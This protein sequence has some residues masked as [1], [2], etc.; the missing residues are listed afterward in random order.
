MVVTVARQYFQFRESDRQKVHIADGRVFLRRS[1]DPYDLI[2]MDAYSHHRYGSFLPHHLVTK[3]FFTLAHERLTT[4]GVLC[5]NVMVGPEGWNSDLVAA[6]DKTLNAVFPQVYL[7]PVTESQNVILVATKLSTRLNF[8]QLHQR[9]TALI[10]QKRVRLPRFRNHI[11][12]LRSDAP[13]TLRNAPVLTD[14]FA[15]LEGLIRAGATPRETPQ[16][17]PPDQEP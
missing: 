11:Y 5:Y 15:P 12:T 8:N 4:N 6:I 10:R 17:A 1:R 16:P 7:F 13:L 9:A 2:V 14:D 3:E